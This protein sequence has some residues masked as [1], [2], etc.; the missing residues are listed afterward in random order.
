MVHDEF[1]RYRI[2]QFLQTID[3]PYVVAWHASRN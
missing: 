3:S 1:T 2:L